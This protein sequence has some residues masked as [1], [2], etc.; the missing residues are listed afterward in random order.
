MASRSMPLTPLQERSFPLP[1]LAHCL[2]LLDFVSAH[3]LI[4]VRSVLLIVRVLLH[5]CLLPS[6]SP[7]S[8]LLRMHPTVVLHS[9]AVVR[10]S[11]SCFPTR[12]PTSFSCCCSVH[13][14][15]PSLLRTMLSCTPRLAFPSLA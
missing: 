5:C 10:A 1:L 12:L 8:T 9:V 2:I 14:S 4:L 3:C 15:C 6:G 13:L 7:L 11:C